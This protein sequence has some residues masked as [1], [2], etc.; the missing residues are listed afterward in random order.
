MST[1][2][3]PEAANPRRMPESY[4]ADYEPDPL[5]AAVYYDGIRMKRIFANEEHLR[6]SSMTAHV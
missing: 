4:A 1:Q 2:N 3:G 5:A 6:I